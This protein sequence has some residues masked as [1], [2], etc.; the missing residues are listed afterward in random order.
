MIDYFYH[1]DIYGR[2]RG[3]SAAISYKTHE[4]SRAGLCDEYSQRNYFPD[5]RI[6]T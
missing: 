5:Q 3:N 4:G 2:N 1:G 6:V